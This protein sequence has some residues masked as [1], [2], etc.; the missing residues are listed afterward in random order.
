ML[1]L[2][3]EGVASHAWH[4]ILLKVIEHMAQG[5]AFINE[6]MAKKFALLG[7]MVLVAVHR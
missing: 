5:D 3:A 6:L 1:R 7:V 2:S 4:P